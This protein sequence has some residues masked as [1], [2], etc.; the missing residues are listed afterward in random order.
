MSH[1]PAKFY[2]V[3]QVTRI[4]TAYQVHGAS[5]TRR[6]D[7]P[8]DALYDRLNSWDSKPPGTLPWRKV[9]GWRTEAGAQRAL[10]KLRAAYGQTVESVGWVGGIYVRRKNADGDL[11]LV[12][13]AQYDADKLAARAAVTS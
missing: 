11:E 10:E 2:V 9:S 1:Q 6:V 7:D 3:I 4:S 13:L 12:P 8:A 5:G